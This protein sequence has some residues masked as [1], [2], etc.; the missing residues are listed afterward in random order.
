MSGTMMRPLWTP[1]SGRSR[2]LALRVSVAGVRLR[3]LL[4]WSP[5]MEW[6]DLLHVLWA[7]VGRDFSGTLLMEV[8]ENLDHGPSTWNQRLHH[9]HGLAQAWCSKNGITP[10]TLEEFRRSTC[11][12]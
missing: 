4:G 11:N 8:A 2:P 6:S 9:L 3:Q 10:S 1:A 5:H 7:G 12:T